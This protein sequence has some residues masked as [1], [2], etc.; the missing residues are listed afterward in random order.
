VCGRALHVRAL[1]HRHEGAMVTHRLASSAGQ[2]DPHGRR[3]TG[4]TTV[5][6]PSPTACRLGVA[7]DGA[8]SPPAHECPL[9]WSWPDW[10]IF[11]AP[12]FSIIPDDDWYRCEAA[13]GLVPVRHLGTVP[14]SWHGAA[15]GDPHASDPSPSRLVHATANLEG[16]VVHVDWVRN[17]WDGPGRVINEFRVDVDHLLAGRGGSFGSSLGAAGDDLPLVARIDADRAMTL[18]RA[19]RGLP[20]VELWEVKRK[21]PIT[22]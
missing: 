21:G 4:R 10:D 15:R 13:R 22:W 17:V 6:T 7:H 2:I 8:D 9:D 18:D 20:I 11:R 19:F 5:T 16:H 1:E 14:L 3:W 12:I